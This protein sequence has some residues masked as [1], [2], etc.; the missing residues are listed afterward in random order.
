MPELGFRVGNDAMTW[1]VL[2]ERHCCC[3]T[4]TSLHQ[5]RAWLCQM[6]QKTVGTTSTID[7]WCRED[8]F[9]KH[10]KG[11]WEMETF[12][13]PSRETETFLVSWSQTSSLYIPRKSFHMPIFGTL[14]PYAQHRSH[15]LPQDFM[16]LPETCPRLQGSQLALL[17]PFFP[18]TYMTEML[19]KLGM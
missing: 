5:K 6:C 18:D 9:G 4:T 14:I 16:A 19:K 7:N 10:G 12:L 8:G 2:G 1:L 15:P 13:V 17:H 11:T 3:P